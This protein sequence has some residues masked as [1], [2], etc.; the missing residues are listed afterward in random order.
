MPVKSISLVLYYGEKK[1]NGPRTYDEAV[2]PI[3][4]VFEDIAKYNMYPIT[5]IVALDYQ[6]FR[7]QDNRDMVKGLQMLYKWKGDLE[8]FRGMKMRKIVAL[9]IAAHAN[10]EELLKIVSQQEKEEGVDMCES[11][12]L[13][14]EKILAEGENK[15]ER[16]GI[17][18]LL[19]YKFGKLSPET[20]EQIKESSTEQLNQLKMK[21]FNIESEK[22][23]VDALTC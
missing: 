16:I 13:Y 19:N 1:W 10:N 11:M 23:I 18:D 7:N 22:D 15:G 2:H 4:A 21:M 3:P 6:L 8:V 14:T 9:I 5:D 20:V 12:R 17:I